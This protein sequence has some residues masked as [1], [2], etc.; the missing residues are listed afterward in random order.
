MRPPLLTVAS[1]CFLCASCGYVGDPLPPALNI[2]SPITDLRA[3]ERGDRLQLDFTIPP[4]TTEGLTLA[5]LGTVELRVGPGG[6]PF[7]TNRW[8]ETSKAYP[9]DIGQT[10]TVHAEVPAA[11]WVGKEVVAGIRVINPKGRSSD[12]SNLVSIRVLPPV[13]APANLVAASD[14]KGVRLRWRS[15][16]RSFRVYRKAPGEKA[17][18]LAGTSEAPE[19]ADA[20]AQFGTPYEYWVEAL[21]DQAESNRSESVVFTPKDEFPPEVPAGLTVVPGIGTVELV[22]D[23]NTEPDLRG[24]RV[25][26]AEEGAA[27]ARLAEW[28]ET[29][30][31]SD[32]A[33]QSGKKY[34][35]TIAALDQAGNESRQSAAVEVTAP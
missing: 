1:L 22:W 20:S 25:Y 10:G 29:P 33:V 5:R 16:E 4:L 32:R 23:R 12:W 31:Y 6:S 24:Y 27:P 3:V 9:L 21:R 15:P 34:R 19:F 13:P 17:P 14:P 28:V 26:R 18:T 7:D 2:A 11:P 35:Y 8:A 30:A